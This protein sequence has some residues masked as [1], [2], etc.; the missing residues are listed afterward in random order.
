MGG[1]EFA[2]TNES[3]PIRI[4]R[5]TQNKLLDKGLVSRLPKVMCHITTHQHRGQ[6]RR[7]SVPVPV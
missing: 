3:P 1:D 2:L 7:W 5:D 6:S 4:S